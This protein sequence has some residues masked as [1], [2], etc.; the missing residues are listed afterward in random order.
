MSGVSEAKRS[1]PSGVPFMPRFATSILFGLLLV[2][3]AL[4]QQP[5][6]GKKQPEGK[7]IS[8]TWDAAYLEGAR[9]GHVH[10]ITREFGA[11]KE[12]VLRTVQELKLSVRRFGQKADMLAEKMTDETPSGLLAGVHFRMMA[13]QDTQLELHAPVKDGNFEIDLDGK[14]VAGPQKTFKIAW[15]KDI[16]GLVREEKLLKGR[17]CKAGNSF[18]YRLF[19]PSVV[20]VVKV[21]VDVKDEEMVV[22]GGGKRILL[23][24]EAKPERIGDV[25]LPVQTLWVD[26]NGQLVAS[27]VMMPGLGNLRIERTTKEIATRP[28]D[29]SKLPDIGQIQAIPLNQRLPF[30]PHGQ[31]TIVFRISLPEDKGDDVT[32]AFAKG[33]GRQEIKNVE[34]KTF[35]LYIHADRKPDPNG[36]NEKV[37]DEYIKSN[38]FL[39]SD[40]PKVQE[41][42]KKA[43]GDEVDPWRKALK[44]ERW[45]KGNMRS[46]NFSIAMAPASEVARNLAGD[47]TEFSMLTAA[48]CK[49]VGIPAR[50]ALG[51]IYYEDQRPMLGFHMWT[52][53]MINGG[54]QGLDATLGLGG[55]GSAHIKITDHSWYETRSL[56][57]LLPVMRVMVGK[58]QIEVLKIEKDK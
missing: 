57:P 38:F 22:L 16:V 28:I 2:F 3:P 14:A 36:K 17:E 55:A 11:G 44:I 40:D 26:N 15:D 51:Y 10:T 12:T 49:A 21:Q 33:D 31:D 18:S 27:Q 56:A 53:V 47:C 46:V 43:V 23:R 25:Q 34:G 50:T 52:E 19:E 4:A 8:E 48:M 6:E 42:A 20:R 1:R 7:I 5:P 54:W 13:G 58:P 32:T 37:R 24:V 39:T 29:P 45:V 30:P 41:L 35:D 9:A